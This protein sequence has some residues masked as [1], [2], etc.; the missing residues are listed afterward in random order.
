MVPDFDEYYP[1]HTHLMDA[2]TKWIADN[3]AKRNIAYAVQ[4]GD[5]TNHN[6]ASEWE[7]ARQA[8][9]TLDGKV[10]Y[11]VV[12]GNHDYDDSGCERRHRPAEH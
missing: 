6:T 12:P 9:A 3:A 8:F 4:L 7:V 11:A 1:R 5:L 2:Q 10:P